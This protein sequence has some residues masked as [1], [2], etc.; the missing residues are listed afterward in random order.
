MDILAALPLHE[1]V[2]DS[3]ILRGVVNG[4]INIEI[5]REPFEGSEQLRKW[6]HIVLLAG[7]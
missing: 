6:E 4:G 2:K 7:V 1:T 3:C 5:R